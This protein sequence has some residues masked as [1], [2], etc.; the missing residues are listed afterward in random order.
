MSK[1]KVIGLVVGLVLVVLIVLLAVALILR[2]D[3][4]QAKETALERSGGGEVVA[5]EIGSEGLWNEYSYVIR[6]GDQWYEIEVNGFGR[7]TEFKSG[8][9]QP[10][11]D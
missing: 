6:N 10:M 11:F 4:A 9:G 3:S 5:E 7:V 2:V 1:K 8:T